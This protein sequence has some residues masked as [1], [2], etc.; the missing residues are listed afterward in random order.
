MDM[1]SYE[2]SLPSSGRF[3]LFPK[4]SPQCHIRKDGLSPVKPYAIATGFLHLNAGGAC[5]R[6]L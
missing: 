2:H 1:C 4:T 3:Y 5:M 6:P